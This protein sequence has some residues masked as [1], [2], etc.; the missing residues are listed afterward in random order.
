MMTY[1]AVRQTKRQVMLKSDIMIWD[2]LGQTERLVSQKAD[3]DTYTTY[4]Y[5]STQF[6]HHFQHK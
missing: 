2:A 4:Y 5:I 6:G 1:E 3:D